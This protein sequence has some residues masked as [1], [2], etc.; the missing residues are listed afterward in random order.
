MRKLLLALIIAIVYGGFAFFGEIQSLPK[1]QWILVLSTITFAGYV[2]RALRWKLLLAN[3]NMKISMWVAFKTYVAGLAFIIT[4]GKLGEV[5]KAEL[6]KN[7]FGF[8][9]KSVVFVVVIERLFDI[10]GLAI[11][12]IMGAFWVA[13]THIKSLLFLGVGI[14]LG[15]LALYIFRKRIKIIEEELERLGDWK[16]ILACTILSPIAW[17]FEI[18]ELVLLSH[19]VNFPIN[20][21]QAA[22]VFTTATLFGNLI[23]TPGGIGAIEIGLI[24][25]LMQY[26]M[27]KSLATLVTLTIRIT[28]FWFG[29]FAGILFWFLESRRS[30]A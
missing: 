3:Q 5:A 14:F 17:A 28:T 21:M 9:R 10:I 27:V 24:G 2:V 20:F 6:M 18:F 16:L 22:F 29:F 25:V 11:L 23:M 7:K 30:R 13:M 26:G 15:L 8:K 4:P 19:F 12:G 1:F